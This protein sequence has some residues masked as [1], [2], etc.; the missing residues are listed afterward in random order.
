MR[1]FLLTW[2]PAKFAYTGLP[3]EASRLTGTNR[4]EDRWSCGNRKDL[5]V[6]SRLY[7]R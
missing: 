2:N 5:P 6:G 4:L 1:T 7:R 3:E